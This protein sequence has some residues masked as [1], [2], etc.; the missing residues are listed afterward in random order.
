VK[1]P[2]PLVRIIPLRKL[3]VSLGGNYHRRAPLQARIEPS[4]VQ[5]RD[6]K[7]NIKLPDVSAIERERER[8]SASTG[9]FELLRDPRGL[10]RASA[11]VN[12]SRNPQAC[13]RGESKV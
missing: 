2:S 6:D 5:A 10:I 11:L 4:R 1:R 9:T 7:E 8:D 3:D 13:T 12:R